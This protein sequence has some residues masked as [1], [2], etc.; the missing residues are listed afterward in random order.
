MRHCN[1]FLPCTGCGLVGE[2]GESSIVMYSYLAR[3]RV[4]RAELVSPVS[5]THWYYGQLCEY[6]GT[7]DGS[8]H[9]L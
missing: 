3:H 4:R 1:V 5:T 6:N 9:L 8:G 7:S 2:D